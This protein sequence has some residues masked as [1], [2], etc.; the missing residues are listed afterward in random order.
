VARGT[1]LIQRRHAWRGDALT[2]PITA[3]DRKRL[4]VELRIENEE[5]RKIAYRNFSL[6]FITLFSIAFTARLRREL[7]RIFPAA[8][9]S[10]RPPLSARFNPLTRFVTALLSFEL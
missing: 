8:A 1:T 10:R 9:H 3:G 2:A 4:I 5:L 6:F 7:R